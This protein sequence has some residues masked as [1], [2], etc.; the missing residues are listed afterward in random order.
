VHFVNTEAHLPAHD[1]TVSRPVRILKLRLLVVTE[2]GSV[3][4]VSLTS[5]FPGRSRAIYST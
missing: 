1:F 3:H 4:T 5:V 2:P